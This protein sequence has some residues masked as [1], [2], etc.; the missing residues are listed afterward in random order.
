MPQ[1]FLAPC[2][3]CGSPVHRH[4]KRQYTF[5]PKCVACRRA[6][7]VGYQLDAIGTCFRCGVNFRQVRDKIFFCSRR[8]RSAANPHGA[9]LW[10]WRCLV[11]FASCRSCANPFTAQS[12]PDGYCSADCRRADTDPPRSEVRIVKCAKCPAWIACHGMGRNRK[13]CDGCRENMRQR[14][15]YR[16]SGHTQRERAELTDRIGDRDGWV[17]QICRRRVSRAAYS[18]A[19]PMSKTLDHIIP[20]SHGGSD[21][22]SNLRI[23]HQRCNSR[24]GN[25]GG[26]E[27]LMLIG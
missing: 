8:C 13:Y 16:V 18:H 5:P 23:A 4:K 2:V 22:P 17:C 15:K 21:D 7:H 9:S 25:R 1:V 10:P 24:R 26:N 19:D 20:R 11:W 27:Q 14:F 6:R 3:E 12:E